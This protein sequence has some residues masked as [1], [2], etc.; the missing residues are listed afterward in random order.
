MAT[1]SK[2]DAV[3]QTLLSDLEEKH[4]GDWALA[5]AVDTLKARGQMGA[6]AEVLAISEAI[7]RAKESL[8]KRGY[9]AY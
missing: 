9:G 8:P 3:A 6:A 7:T 4:S 5:L 2:R 1:K